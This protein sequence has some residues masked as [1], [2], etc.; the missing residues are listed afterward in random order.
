MPYLI[1]IG[2]VIAIITWFTL[3]N[4]K[5]ADGSYIEP[6][7]YILFGGGLIITLAGVFLA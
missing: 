7:F 4:K 2:I 3:G 5:P 1:V 6:L